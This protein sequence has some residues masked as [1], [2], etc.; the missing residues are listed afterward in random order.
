[1][2][3]SVFNNNIL[4]LYIPTNL[5]TTIGYTDL[6]VSFSKKLGTN[7][8]GNVTSGTTSYVVS[9]SASPFLFNGLTPGTAYNVYVTNLFNNTLIKSKTLTISTAPYPI[10][11]NAPAST[12]IALTITNP[13]ANTTYSGNTTT[14]I[15]GV[16]TGSVIT[17]SSLTSSTAYTINVYGNING[18][19]TILPSINVSTTIPPMISYSNV[20][21]TLG[22][23]TGSTTNYSYVQVITNGSITLNIPTGKTLYYVIIGGGGAGGNGGSSAYN[24]AGTGGGGGGYYAN[25]FSFSGSFIF[26]CTIG[27]GGPSSSH[28]D[29]GD[30]GAT[31][32]K[33]NPNTN[34]NGSTGYTANGGKG[35]KGLVASPAVGAGGITRTNNIGTFLTVANTDGKAVNSSPSLGIC[36]NLDVSFNFCGGGGGG[37]GSTIAETTFYGIQND[38]IGIYNGINSQGYGYS[39]YG[40]GYGGKASTGYNAYSGYPNTG[41]GSGGGRGYNGGQQVN[42]SIGAAGCVFFFWQK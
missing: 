1:M 6:Q 36:I 40:G 16:T 22:A 10:I 14:G 21:G 28:A 18:F 24:S 23:R 37:G 15:V 32:L 35:G 7:F 30:G 13:T 8:T 42:N 11:T 12:S 26:T 25:S 17:V 20:T 3:N 19:F 5:Q 9:S 39:G 41:S 27:S 29:G 38:I 4:N 33:C 31:N 2:S 34:F